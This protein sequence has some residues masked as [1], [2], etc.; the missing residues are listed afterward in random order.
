MKERW[1]EEHSAINLRMCLCS[2]SF[3][4]DNFI[5]VIKFSASILDIMST[6]NGFPIY[7]FPVSGISNMHPKHL[8]GLVVLCITSSEIHPTPTWV[9]FR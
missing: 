4:D 7:K 2:F 9:K 6:C 8:V 3:H 5:A 1:I